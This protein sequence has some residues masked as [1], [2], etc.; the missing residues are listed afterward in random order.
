M[1]LH[2]ISKIIDSKS[3]LVGIVLQHQ[4]PDLGALA[5]VG[6]AKERVKHPRARQLLSRGEESI[7][8]NSAG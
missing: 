1:L 5:H 6:K 8:P 4:N 2:F 3:N 7:V